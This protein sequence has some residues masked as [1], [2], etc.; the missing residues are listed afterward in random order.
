MV[1]PV[2][3]AAALVHDVGHLPLSHTF[4]GLGGLHHH[5]L[6][7]TRLEDLRDVFSR[8]GIDVAEIAAIVQG[9]KPTMLT[10]EPGLLKLDHL[11][12]FVRS[13]RA[14]GT[15][16]GLPVPPLHYVLEPGWTRPDRTEP[17]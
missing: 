11:D 17:D 7:A 3:R 12:S 8:H 13:G 6:G 10:A 4:E 2:Y 16:L 9:R 1:G 15:L 14:H 5:E